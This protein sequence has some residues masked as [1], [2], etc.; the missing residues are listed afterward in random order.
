MTD[1]PGNV[2]NDARAAGIQLTVEGSRLRFRAPGNTLTPELRA[3]LA[4]YRHQLVRLL[5]DEA[6]REATLAPL[7]INQRGLWLVHCVAPDTAAY[8]VVV[9]ARA[10]GALDTEA[11]R[12]ALQILVDRHESLRTTFLV[13]D[14]GPQRR[15]VGHYRVQLDVRDV[16]GSDEAGVRQQ[17]EALHAQPFDLADGPILRTAAFRVQRDDHII[18]LVAHHIAVDGTSLFVLL[19]EMLAAY[20]ALVDGRPVPPRTDES[21][22]SE[23]ARWQADALTG[24]DA[25]RAYWSQVLDPPP[26]PLR[27]PTDRPRPDLPGLRGDSEGYIFEPHVAEALRGLAS[28]EGTTEFVLMLTLWFVF[29]H[30]LTGQNDITVGTPTHGRPAARFARTVGNL[31]NMIPLRVR[32]IGTQSF[33]DLLAEVRTVALEGMTHQDYP[34][35]LMVEGQRQRGGRSGPP[36]QT[37]FV[38]QV[39]ASFPEIERLLLSRGDHAFAVGGL[40]LEPYPIDQMEGQF[41]LSVDLWPLQNGELFCSWRYDTDLFDAAT[42]RRWSEAFALLTVEAAADP[43]RLISDFTLIQDREAAAAGDIEAAEERDVEVFEI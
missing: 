34:L 14:G 2:L 26:P 4:T 35:P 13:A 16:S 39:F 30:G 28:A 9:A 33:R 18:L 36:F 43:T 38:R 6:E 21:S 11:L 25:E 7:A 27:L 23:F 32:D 1:L 42:I 29:L 24:A 22:F 20:A 40:H 41:D 19:E 10:R 37:M 12:E 5:R 3:R 31:M 15:T 8:N 17:V